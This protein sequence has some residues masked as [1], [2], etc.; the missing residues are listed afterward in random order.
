MTKGE[1]R[2][3]CWDIG[4]EDF[5]DGYVS[6]RALQICSV[7]SRADGDLLRA[8]SPQQ[9]VPLPWPLP[10][11]EQE[12]SDCLAVPATPAALRVCD[13]DGPLA[14]ELS[15]HDTRNVGCRAHYLS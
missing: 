6:Q 8:H 15:I 5:F 7:S 1:N 14:G 11:A 10:I 9:R 4:P 13:L 2:D 3:D 12:V